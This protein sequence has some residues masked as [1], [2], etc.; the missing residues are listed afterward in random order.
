L[1]VSNRVRIIGGTHR[2][3]LIA[4]PEAEGLR[5][6]P[7]RV[8]E[9]LFNWLGQTL[10]GKDCLDL[11]AGAGA[12]GFEAASRE[13]RSVVMV[14]RDDRVFKALAASAAAL[15]MGNVELV[16][17]DALEY[18]A[19]N[20]RK[21]NVIFLDPPYQS[22]LLAKALAGAKGCLAEDGQVYAESGT[23]LEPGP[24]WTTWRQG[25]AGGVFFYLLRPGDGREAKD[26]GTGE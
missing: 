14:E 24:E 20:R 15:K 19:R 2:R 7:D 25:K 17:G 22:D 21:F 8:R 16:R 10:E 13:A 11:F 9:T 4:F 23:P 26:K 5:P 6:T 12:L 3:R 18:A 1:S